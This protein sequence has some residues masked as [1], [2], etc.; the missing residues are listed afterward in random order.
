MTETR[1]RSGG[2]GPYD[3]HGKVAVVT[4]ASSGIGAATARA[5]AR[6]GAHVVV[7]YNSG[8]DR[9]D[10]VVRTLAGDGHQALRLPIEDTPALKIAA[11][12]VAER[13]GEVHVLVNSAGSTAK[14]AHDDL[15]T[16]TDELFDAMLRI[17]V[18]GPF[19]VIRAFVPLLRA[20]GDAVVVNISSVSGTTASGSNIAYC[21]AKAALD[22]LTMSLGRALG[23]GIRFVGVAP[24]AVETGFVAGRGRDAIAA[25]AASTPLK[26]LVHPDDIAEAVLGVVRNMRVVTGTTFMVDGGKH[27]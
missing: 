13:F 9:A 4:G 12:Q 23:P 8:P 26:V 17:N 14:V 16:M 7:G 25:Q 24:A 18:R 11:A 1:L 27:L 6:A 2:L 10:E 3:L 21:A 15:E 19:A 5:L 20:G 22:N